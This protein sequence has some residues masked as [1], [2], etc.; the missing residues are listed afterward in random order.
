MVARGPVSLAVNVT[1]QLDAAGR[2]TRVLH[3]QLGHVLPAIEPERNWRHRTDLDPDDDARALLLA[4]LLA[5]TTICCHLRRGGP[6]PAIARLPLRRVDCGR[7]VQTL[8]R[9]TAGE[10]QC[11][12][13]DATDVDMFHPFAVNRGPLLIAGDACGGCAEVLGIVQEASA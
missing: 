3:D 7:C 11:D 2:E 8:Y 12:V 13:C 1:D 9:S 5:C 10:D 4:A 6:Q